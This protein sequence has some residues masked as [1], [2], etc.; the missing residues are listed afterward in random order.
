MTYRNA[1]SVLLTNAFG[2]CLALLEG[3]LVLELGAHFGCRLLN[4]FGLRCSVCDVVYGSYE[5]VSLRFCKAA[6]DDV[7][8]G[9]KQAAGR[10]VSAVKAN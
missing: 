10:Q 9:W 1:I 3:V 2:F 6:M 4:G 8:V 5:A 7:D